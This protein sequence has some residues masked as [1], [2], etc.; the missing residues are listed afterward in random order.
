MVW[1]PR[2][3]DLRTRGTVPWQLNVPLEAATV[4][5][6][7]VLARLGALSPLRYVTTTPV[8]GAKPEPEATT[9]V[10]RFPLAGDNANLGTGGAG[11]TG[12]VI[13]VTV[14]AAVPETTAAESVA[15]I[16]VTPSP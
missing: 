9:G 7:T 3:P 6:N 12:D 13:G 8:P 11:D 5:H 16:V 14:S 1:T 15:V 4:W 10:L 2:L